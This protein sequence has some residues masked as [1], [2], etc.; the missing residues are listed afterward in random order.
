[1]TAI[2]K[3]AKPHPSAKNVV[4]GKNLAYVRTW[5]NVYKNVSGGEYK[6][7]IP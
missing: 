3:S 4:A 1:M 2:A 6:F 7:K 5:K